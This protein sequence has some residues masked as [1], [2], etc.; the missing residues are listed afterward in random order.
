MSE[1]LPS[2]DLFNQAPPFVLDYGGTQVP[3]A[4]V[5]H[6]LVSFMVEADLDVAQARLLRDWLNKVI[7]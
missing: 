5:Y 7:P 2:D 1:H 6:G 3:I 4:T